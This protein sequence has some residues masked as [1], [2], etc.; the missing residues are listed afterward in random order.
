VVGAA[1]GAQIQTLTSN[2]P[3]E[4]LP[5]KGKN[6]RYL[7]SASSRLFVGCLRGLLMYPVLCFPW[8]YSDLERLE[9]WN[10]SINIYF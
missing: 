5:A 4:L 1:L 9:G 10:M 6:G 2:Y 8:I 7:S 3:L